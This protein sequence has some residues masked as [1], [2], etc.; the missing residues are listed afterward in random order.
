M[1]LLDLIFLNYNCRAKKKANQEE[2]L[3]IKPSDRNGNDV[4]KEKESMKSEPQKETLLTVSA[5][6][7]LVCYVF[8]LSC[9]LD[10]ALIGNA[11]IFYIYSS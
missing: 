9:F 1:Y 7:I 5:I 6:L 11:I 10:V 3:L 8:S 4:E 2:K